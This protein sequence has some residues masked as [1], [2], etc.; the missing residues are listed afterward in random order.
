MRSSMHA[1][2]KKLKKAGISSDEPGLASLTGTSNKVPP[3]GAVG[4]RRANG[5]EHA[6]PKQR[7]ERKAA[8][9]PFPRKPETLPPVVSFAALA[10]VPRSAD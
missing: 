4:K 7:R 3:T 6:A 2:T 10:E 9:A 5:Q 1:I 8:A